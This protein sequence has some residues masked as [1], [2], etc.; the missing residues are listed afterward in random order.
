MAVP[1]APTLKSPIN[2]STIY[3]NPPELVWYS[4]PEVDVDSYELIFWNDRGG[5]PITT[6][7][8]VAPS[9]SILVYWAHTAVVACSLNPLNAWQWKVR[10]HNPTGW[11]AYSATWSFQMGP[12]RVIAS[13]SPLDYSAY[14]SSISLGLTEPI[15]FNWDAA[16]GEQEWLLEFADDLAFTLNLV[17]YSLGVSPLILTPDD[18]GIFIQGYRYW[19]IKGKISN[20]VPYSASTAIMHIHPNLGPST[21]GMTISG[22]LALWSKLESSA[23]IYL[24]EYGVGYGSAVNLTYAPGRFT[25]G[26]QCGRSVLA[27]AQYSWFSLPSANL[28]TD[29]GCIEFW[30]KRLPFVAGTGLGPVFTTGATTGITM[31]YVVGVLKVSVNVGGGLVAQCTT[32]IDVLPINKLAHVAVTWDKDA[33]LTGGAGLMLFINNV[34]L[35]SDVSGAYGSVAHDSDIVF[36]DPSLTDM[37]G[38]VDNL[39]VWSYG[40]EDFADRDTEIPFTLAAIGASPWLKTSSGEVTAKWGPAPGSVGYYSVK[41]GYEYENY[42]ILLGDEISV[43]NSLVGNVDNLF[44]DLFGFFSV[45]SYAENIID[46]GTI[47]DTDP[48]ALLV[49]TDLTKAWTIDEHKDKW[50]R[51]NFGITGIFYWK[52]ASNTATALTLTSPI[53][54]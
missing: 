36:G 46:S 12:I 40:K 10:A 24:P 50:V 42:Y 22:T 33:G 15:V 47:T 41:S 25:Y 16:W 2:L 51:V 28:P 21:P 52:I 43:G 4:N 8:T 14:F 19:R 45:K 34:L 49:I 44:N 7:V 23:D 39:K 20:D 48:G 32:S 18:V 37:Y 35:A 29:I 17:Q 5:S 9:G 13:T 54:R 38:I 53:R 30:F 3:T 31:E 6:T 27:P 1:I 26:A 11:G